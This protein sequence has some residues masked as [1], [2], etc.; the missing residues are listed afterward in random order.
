MFANLVTAAKGLFTR[1]ESEEEHAGTASDSATTSNMVSATR[2]G[3]VTAQPVQETITKGSVKHGKRKAQPTSAVKTDEKQSKRRKRNSLEAGN[4]TD[5]DTGNSTLKKLAVNDE[6]SSAPKNHFRF[7]SEDPDVPEI[8]EPQPQTIHE[9]AHDDE[10]EDSDD[11]A[12]ESID[13]SAQLLKIKEQA[14][15]QEK[16]KQLEEQ[17]KREKRRKLDERRKLQAKLSKPNELTSPIDDL[18]SESTVTVQGSNTQDA[19]QRAL[20]ALL[21]D[22]ILN[23]EPVIRPPT[24][25]AEDEFVLPKKPNKLRFLERTEKAPKDVCVGDVTIRVLDAP[26]TKKNTKPALAPKS[27]KSGRNLKENWLKRERSTAHANG[28]RRTI[29]GSSGFKRR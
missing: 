3:A 25:E 24:P 23:A 15:K 8:P 11:E 17:V 21:P 9:N 12:P 16:A 27:S 20:P 13:N 22:D 7:G 29:G 10:E 14:K 6:K 4:A 2:R 18:M 5:D 26:S 19:R 28:L 1:H